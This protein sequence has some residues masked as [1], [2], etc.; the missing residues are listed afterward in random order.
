MEGWRTGRK[1]GGGAREGEG[2]R[3]ED[4]EGEK[5]DVRSYDISGHSEVCLPLLPHPGIQQVIH[6]GPPWM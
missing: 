6:L 4:K 5:G 3:K 2:K 1:E